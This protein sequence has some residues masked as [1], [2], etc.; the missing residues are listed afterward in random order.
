MSICFRSALLLFSASLAWA[1][2]PTTVLTELTAPQLRTILTGLGFES[3]EIT[4]D[5][6]TTF[7]LKIDGADVTLFDWGTS[8]ELYLKV[9]DKF[10]PAK[11]NDWNKQHRFSKAY[12]DVDGGAAL[13][14]DLDFTGGVTKA[15]VAAFL[16]NFERTLTPWRA[17]FPKITTVTVANSSP[18]V[19]SK[20]ARKRMPTAF[21]N[22]ALW[23]DETRWKTGKSDEAGVMTFNDF[24]GA[25]YAKVISE[26]IGIP[27][28]ALKGIA[29]AN[30]KKMAPD[31]KI[32]LEEKR[33]VNGKQVL[34]LQ[35]EGS[36]QDIPFRFYGYFH[37]GT[38][39][40]IQA[41]TWT[42]A[43]LFADSEASFTEFLDGL[44]ILD[45][46]LPPAPLPSAIPGTSTPASTG[47]LEMNA[48]KMSLKYDPEK[49]T[50]KPSSTAG[51]FTFGHKNGDGYA[52]V[53]AE[54]LTVPIDSLPDIALANA[55]EAAPDA[56]ITFRE[57][58]TIAGVE[59]WFLKLSVTASGVPLSYYGYY[60]SGKAGTI[61]I[62]TYTG[63]N[64]V[65]EY[66]KDFL[67]FLNGFR[68][69]DF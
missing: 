51:H 3:T 4:T 17:L 59:V 5:K 37:G 25:G 39:G 2:T 33:T 58:R 14:A 6:L 32:V 13:E 62:L 8:I 52:L 10:D 30:M 56:S 36:Y 27:T 47:L 41:I 45:D 64:L 18:H 57:K 19:H 68:I 26:R 55:K 50:Q 15:A 38:S 9:A 40:T 35:Y 49:W 60:Y 43:I 42:S 66:E 16:Q 31:A 46:E 12:A 11:A 54:R 22:F 65:A 1:Q 34:V 63:P 48:G 29:L 44:E 53:V 69:A 24:S 28:D 7:H 20:D 23:V 67:E 21:G 61:Q